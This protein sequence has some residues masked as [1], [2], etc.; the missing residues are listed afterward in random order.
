MLLAIVYE[1]LNPLQTYVYN[2]D[3]YKLGS[4]QQESC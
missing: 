4:I 2:V 1:N 3:I